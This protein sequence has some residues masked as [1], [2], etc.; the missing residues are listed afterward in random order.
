MPAALPPQPPPLV[1]PLG[2]SVKSGDDPN[3]T[4]GVI[5]PIPSLSRAL[6]DLGLGALWKIPVTRIV[7]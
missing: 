4:Q 1:D 5:R 6:W 7:P 3:A 2:I